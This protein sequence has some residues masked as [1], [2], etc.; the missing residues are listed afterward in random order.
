MY[1]LPCL[2]NVPVSPLIGTNCVPLFIE[3]NGSCKFFISWWPL[4]NGLTLMGQ[5]EVNAFKG[6]WCLRVPMIKTLIKSIHPYSRFKIWSC[7]TSYSYIYD[8]FKEIS[9]YI[10]NFTFWYN[11]LSTSYFVLYLYMICIVCVCIMERSPLSICIWTLIYDSAHY[12][13]T[14]Y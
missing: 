8:N 9:V 10:D 2:H 11:K 14:P 4:T 7:V 3:S 1:T 12:S 6:I 5:L 13:R